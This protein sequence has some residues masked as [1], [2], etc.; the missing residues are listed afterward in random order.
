MRVFCDYS[1]T[2]LFLL[3]N[4]CLFRD[5]NQRQKNYGIDL[6]IRLRAMIQAANIK[7]LETT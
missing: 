3:C 1:V 4:F 6:T 5:H 7:E 2:K